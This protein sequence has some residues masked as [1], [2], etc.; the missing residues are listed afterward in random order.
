MMCSRFSAAQATGRASTTPR[1]SISTQQVRS[2][3]TCELVIG[4]EAQALG[5]C[6][7]QHL[8]WWW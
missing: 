8:R 1:A 3:R 7:M 4:S 5:L 2:G 6:S